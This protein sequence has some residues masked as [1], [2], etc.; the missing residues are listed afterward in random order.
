MSPSSVGPE[1]VFTCVCVSVALTACNCTAC[2]NFQQQNLRYSSW[3]TVRLVAK[4]R[5]ISSYGYIIEAN[6]RSRHQFG[7][8][9]GS[10]SGPFEVSIA[11]ELPWLDVCLLASSNVIGKIL[12]FVTLW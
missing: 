2:N 5:I 8:T 1:Y 10:R 4:H 12:E 7:T 11:E 3:E 6:R 9:L